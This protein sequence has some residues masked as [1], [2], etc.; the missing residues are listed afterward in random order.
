MTSFSKS[1]RD[2]PEKPKKSPFSLEELSQSVWGR[3][4]LFCNESYKKFT[5][6]NEEKRQESSKN[7]LIHRKCI[8]L[9]LKGQPE[10]WEELLEKFNKSQ[11]DTAENFYYHLSRKKL[12]TPL[13]VLRIW[14]IKLTKFVELAE[15]ALTPGENRDLVK[16]GAFDDIIDEFNKSSSRTFLFLVR[17]PHFI[18]DPRDRAM[19]ES[20]SGYQKILEAGSSQYLADF[21]L[22]LQRKF[23]I[24]RTALKDEAAQNLVGQLEDT[25]R[26]LSQQ[27]S[28]LEAEK[29][30]LN[31]QLE[32]SKTHAF[33][34]AVFQLGKTL[35]QQSQPVLD[36]LLILSKRLEELTSEDGTLSYTDALTCLIT[37]EA[38]LKAFKAINIS[39]Y[40]S[41]TEAVFTINGG[42][43]S[44]YNYVA[45]TPF[46]DEKDHKK[47][48]CL[49]PGWRVGEQ[50][51]TPARVEE[52]GGK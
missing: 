45:G 8:D 12:Q 13:Q 44:E 15:Y 50:V 19:V 30:E 47:V 39:S 29:Q 35:Q 4:A 52:V 36:Q 28:I 40:P 42:Q 10:E 48:R 27:I 18:K 7:A 38:L 2:N 20:S 37:I 23:R 26:N 9:L 11:Y 49:Y 3:F 46:K 34:E 51:V 22:E 17:L 31:L 25:E 5:P 1:Y 24:T 41:D 21:G 14:N 33:Q 6:V 16:L 43:L 32:R